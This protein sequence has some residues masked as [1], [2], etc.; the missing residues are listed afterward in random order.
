MENT[1]KCQYKRK[2]TLRTKAWE[3]L[4]IFLW[5]NWVLPL[6]WRSRLEQISVPMLLDEIEADIGRAG[7]LSLSPITLACLVRLRLAYLTHWRRKRCLLGSLLLLYY[8]ARTQREVTLHLQCTLKKNEQVSGHCWITGPHLK[9]AT[10]WMPSEGTDDIYRKTIR[11]PS[12]SYT[13]S[14]NDC[15]HV[16]D[17]LNL[18]DQM[19]I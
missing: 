6:R 15:H 16:E 14:M 2:A 3:V 18:K 19:F 5:E 11:P 10:R 4:K 17:T 9:R 8:L 1:Q 7:W 12:F 13:M